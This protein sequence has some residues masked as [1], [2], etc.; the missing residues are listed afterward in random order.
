MPL[1]A[2]RFRQAWRTACAALHVWVMA[3][4][5]WCRQKNASTKHRWVHTKRTHV[6]QEMHTGTTLATS[7]TLMHTDA[8]THQPTHRLARPTIETWH[9]TKKEAH[10]RKV[11]A[12]KPKKERIPAKSERIPAKSERARAGNKRWGCMG[13][14][15]AL[16]R[17]GHALARACRLLSMWQKKAQKHRCDTGNRNNSKNKNKHLQ[18]ARTRMC[19]CLHRQLMAANAQMQPQNKLSTL[20]WWGHTLGE[21]GAPAL[22]HAQQVRCVPDAI[23]V[24]HARGPRVA[25]TSIGACEEAR[26]CCDCVISCNACVCACVNR[27]VSKGGSVQVCLPELTCANE[28]TCHRVS[29]RHRLSTCI[30]VSKF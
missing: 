9:Q 19:Q 11:G 18:A 10:P 3:L 1:P 22:H 23:P 15:Q 16:R 30:R 8:H 13:A 20:R 21:L 17:H 6:I 29:T 14:Q 28:H 7:H 27:R 5:M 12:C 2:L 25:C 4:T 24:G 26:A